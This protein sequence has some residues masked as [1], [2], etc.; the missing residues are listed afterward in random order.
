MSAGISV[1]TA[2]PFSASAHVPHAIRVALGSVDLEVLGPALEMVK[3][4]ID[5][6]SC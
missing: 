4:V 2:D 1:S 6:H 5:D 3:R